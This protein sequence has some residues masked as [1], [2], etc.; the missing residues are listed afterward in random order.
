MDGKIR[1]ELCATCNLFN[2]ETG[3]GGVARLAA[4][5]GI[6]ERSMHRK[7]SEQHRIAERD[8]WAVEDAVRELRQRPVSDNIPA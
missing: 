6:T 2:D 5:I 4:L 1:I 8:R 3:R 7:I